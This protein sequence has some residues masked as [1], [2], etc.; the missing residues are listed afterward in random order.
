MEKR[1]LG[2]STL[3][4]FAFL[5]IFIFHSFP[6]FEFGYFGVDFFYLIS[7][8]LLTFLF[9][10]EVD[11]NGKFNVIHFFFRRC[12][13][14]YPLY[15]W[16]LIFSFFVLP[17]I[18]SNFDFIIKLPEN[19]FYY[20]FFLSNYDHSEHIFALKLLWS[21]SLEEQFYIVF[22]ML[23]FFFLKWFKTLMLSLL[24][25]LIPFYIPFFDFLNLKSNLFNHL[26]F[27]IAGILLG[28]MF[29]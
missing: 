8:F 17:L 10:K 25:I 22:I 24:L 19:Q 18:V 28:K 2:I 21:I 12:L 14:I 29:Y 26:P 27:F 4:F 1:I 13:K 6:H 11:K 9:F 23:S 3:R 5:M 20:W 15:F 7:S 16:I